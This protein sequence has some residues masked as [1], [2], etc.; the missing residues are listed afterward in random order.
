MTLNSTRLSRF[1]RTRPSFP[2]RSPFFGIR[3]ILERCS[4][5]SPFPKAFQGHIGVIQRN[6]IASWA[7]LQLPRQPRPE[8][9]LFGNDTG[10]AKVAC[11]LG[12]IKA[13]RRQNLPVVDASRIAPLFHQ[14]HDY[15]HV[16]GGSDQV[17][18]GKETEHNFRL[19]GGVQHACTLLDVTHELTPDGTIRRVRFRKPL[20]KMKTWAWRIFVERT[21]GIR[22]SLRL[23]RKF[24][25]KSSAS[26]GD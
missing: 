14:Q 25:Q 12:V 6:A 17:L 22:D 26:S 18:R 11:E 19:Y 16:P 10:T 3:V 13:M 15:N 4:R 24:W 7:R 9:I 1:K 21:V 5:F 23:R 8:I 2:E 20:Y